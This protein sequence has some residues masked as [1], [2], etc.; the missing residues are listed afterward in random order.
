MVLSHTRRLDVA[1]LAIGV[2]L[3]LASCGTGTVSSVPHPSTPVPTVNMIPT[4]VSTQGQ[5]LLDTMSHSL[6]SARTLHG[7][8]DLSITG[9]TINGNLKT[10]VW[11]AVPGKSR[12]VVLRS[13]LIQPATGTITVADGKQQWE[14]DPAQKVIYKGKITSSTTDTSSQQSIFGNGESNQ[15]LFLLDL[16]QNVLTHSAGTLKSSQVH[17]EGHT[18]YDIGVV[19]ASNSTNTTASPGFTYT[20]DVYLDENTLHPIQVNLQIQGFGSVI[21][22]LLT[23]ELNQPISNTTFTFVEPPHAKILP[24]SQLNATSGS[25]SGKMTFVQAQQQ[26]GYHLLSIPANNYDVTLDGVDALGPP[27]NQ[28]YTLNYMKGNNVFTIAEGKSLSNLP[29][30]G[31]QVHVRG[32]AAITSSADGNTTLYWTESGVG[33]RITSSL[34]SQQT[35]S[36]AESLK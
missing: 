26:A 17:V 32:L 33:I 20:G 3:L 18:T 35:E 31:Q 27:G 28:T 34:D 6:N 14:Y 13:S 36:I 11:D 29:V 22:N 21:M 7:I 4:P 25:D 23:L 24:F 9:E 30:T 1:F 15:S 19:P 10:E 12:T 16:M 2:M 8:F 5:K